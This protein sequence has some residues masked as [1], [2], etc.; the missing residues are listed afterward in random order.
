MKKLLT[1]QV[2][3]LK[4]GFTFYCEKISYVESIISSLNEGKIIRFRTGWGGTNP[5]GTHF[6][7]SHNKT[8]ECL[9]TVGFDGSH[10]ILVRR[11]YEGEPEYSEQW[12]CTDEEVMELV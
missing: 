3:D 11:I 10:K 2:R 1:Y 9:I 4:E 6:I 7:D 5:S 12:V 8:G